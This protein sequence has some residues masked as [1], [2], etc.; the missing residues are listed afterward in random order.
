MR[1]FLRLLIFLLIFAFFTKKKKKRFEGY[2]PFDNTSKD[3]ISTSNRAPY[4]VLFLGPCWRVPGTS[5][6]SFAFNSGPHAIFFWVHTDEGLEC[7][8][9]RYLM[10]CCFYFSLMWVAI[11]VFFI[12]S[13]R[14]SRIASSRVSVCALTTLHQTTGSRENFR[15]WKNIKN[16]VLEKIFIVGKSNLFSFYVIKKFCWV[17]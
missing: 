11:A 5:P 8:E 13:S 9:C 6:S 12:L 15:N 4:A 14:L 17:W 7:L 3:R 16:L 2:G 1:S 10:I